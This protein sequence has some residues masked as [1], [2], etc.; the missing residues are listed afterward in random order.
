MKKITRIIFA[1]AALFYGRVY[2]NVTEKE[3]VWVL[4][5][6]TIMKLDSALLE[7]QPKRQKYD[8]EE[9][10]PNTLPHHG[11]SPNP[12]VRAASLDIDEALDQA[13]EQELDDV[14]KKGMCAIL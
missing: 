4:V 7:K 14:W 10:I 3:L 8:P 2:A 13:L 5:C 6:K 11:P 12:L 9:Q 1:L